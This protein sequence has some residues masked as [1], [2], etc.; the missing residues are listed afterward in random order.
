MGGG[1][2]ERQ[3]RQ[4]QTGDV[5][6]RRPPRFG[7]SACAALDAPR[8]QPR[9]YGPTRLD[10]WLIVPVSSVA[11]VTL[12]VPARL[13]A[14]AAVVP[15]VGVEAVAGFDRDHAQDLAVM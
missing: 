13:A 10:A 1:E 11:P 7:E 3:Q 4:T 5:A 6:G 2:P 9:P 14:P 15:A 12:I 8:L